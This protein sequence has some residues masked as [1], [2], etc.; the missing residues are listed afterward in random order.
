VYI[1]GIMKKTLFF[2][3]S[4]LMCSIWAK[5]QTYILYGTTYGGG[6]YGNGT[7]FSYNLSSGKEGVLINFDTLN[8]IGPLGNLI[9][10]T[11]SKLLYATTYGGGANNYGIVFSYDPATNKDSTLFMFNGLNGK[12]PGQG[13][14]YGNNGY[15]YGMTNGGGRYGFGTLFSYNKI[16]G[17]DSV[18]I[19]FDTSSGKEYGPLGTS[20]TLNPSNGLLYG[21]T[22][23]GGKNNT[24]SIFSFDPATGKDSVVISLDSSTG[25]QPQ[26]GTLILDPINKSFY[27]VTSSGG[28]H[29]N[30]VLFKYDLVKGKDS[31]VINFNFS[32]GYYPYGGLMY[33]SLNGLFYGLTSAGGLY[34]YG[35]LYSFDPVSGKQNVLFNF[36]D[37]LGSSPS[38]NITLGPNGKLYGLANNDQNGNGLLFRYDPVAAKYSVLFY[39]NYTNGSGPY[40]SLTLV[41][42]PVVTSANAVAGSNNTRIYPNPFTT[43]TMLSFNEGGIHY[44]E[45]DNI[46]GQEISSFKCGTRN[47]ELQRRQLATGIY[48]V[49]I[50]DAQRSFISASKII[51][52]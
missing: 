49:K 3:I 32:N 7:I 45:I 35:I 48:F 10:D 36:N 9:Q 12:W 18:I 6:T 31:A 25:T 52:Q 46:E 30:G 11:A 42:N 5:S 24:G 51:V 44:V 43:N 39:F 2:G 4:F 16:S 50:Y 41:T 17:K 15:L 33:D 47:Y 20:L 34:D 28:I 27:G 14:L 19:N 8:G 13:S 29:N 37:T 26:E 1:C 40:G 22:Y 23:S 21:M 38:G